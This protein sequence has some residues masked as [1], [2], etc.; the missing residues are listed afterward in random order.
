MTKSLPPGGGSFP[1]GTLAQVLMLVV[2]LIAEIVENRK[3]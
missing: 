1:W 3:K 2:T